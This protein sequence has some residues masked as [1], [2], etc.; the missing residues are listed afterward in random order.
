M[1]KSGAVLGKNGWPVWVASISFGIIQ[2]LLLLLIGAYFVLR[3]KNNNN[4]EKNNNDKNKAT[5]KKTSSSSFLLD[6]IGG[7]AALDAAVHRFYDR[8]LNDKALQV[9]FDGADVAK[10]KNHQ[11]RFLKMAFTKIPSTYD[12][13][14]VML[15]KHKRLFDMGLNADHFDLVAGHL[16]EALVSLGVTKDCIE[17]A[18]SIV[19]PLRAIFEQGSAIAS[20]AAAAAPTPDDRDDVLVKKKYAA[21][22][23]PPTSVYLLD[24]M[25]GDAALDAA[26]EGF[27]DRILV[28][29]KLERF[30]INKGTTD[31]AKLKTHQRRFLK[32]AFTKIPSTYN[33][34]KVM[35]DKHERLFAMGLNAQHFD[36]VAGHLVATLVSLGVSQDCIDEA[37]AIVS[38]LRSVFEQGAVMMGGVGVGVGGQQ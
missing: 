12:V 13:S 17:E 25:G 6:R 27:Y 15:D 4:T 36:L 10:L 23:A 29:P 37:V 18:V 14:K 38:P 5:A 35:L 19:G 21:A 26:V 1:P 34:T 2:G 8:V 16:V 33:V 11:Y 22:A 7:D 3:R 30:F 31:I 9:F 32:M 28:D 24:R 20:A